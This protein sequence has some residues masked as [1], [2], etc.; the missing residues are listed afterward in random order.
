[1]KNFLLGCFVFAIPA[2]DFALVVRMV[3]IVSVPDLLSPFFAVLLGCVLGV[4]VCVVCI[5]GQGNT[6]IE[7]VVPSIIL[8]VLLLIMVPVAHKARTTRRANLQKRALKLQ[9]QALQPTPRPTR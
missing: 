5:A 9:K 4:V 6:V 3:Y 1:M 7:I 2:L 8:L